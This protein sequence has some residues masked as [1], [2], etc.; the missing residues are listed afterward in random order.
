[1]NKRGEF[2]ATTSDQAMMWPMAEMCGPDH[3]CAI[4]EVLYIY[5]RLNPLSDDRVHRVDQLTTEQSIRGSNSSS[6]DLIYTLELSYH[7]I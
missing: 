6:L 3:F 2:W 1:M 7:I 5:N 4:N